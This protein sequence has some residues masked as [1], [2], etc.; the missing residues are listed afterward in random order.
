MKSKGKG[1]KA[2]PGQAV[3]VS[4]NFKLPDFM[5]VGTCKW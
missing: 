2:I 4:R 3:S 1:G 5:T